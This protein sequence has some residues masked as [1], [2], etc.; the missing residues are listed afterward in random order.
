MRVLKTTCCKM[1][2][3]IVCITMLC[4]VC[5]AADDAASQDGKNVR[6]VS[7]APSLTE[8][9]AD[10][11][12]GDMLVGRSSACDYPP[13][14]VDLPVAGDFGRPFLEA[15]RRLNPDLVVATDVERPQVMAYL[16]QAG[17]R[18][19][20]R[21]CESWDEMMEAALVISETLGDIERGE[22]WVEQM[23][24]RRRLLEE[25]VA[26]YWKERQR[27]RVFV[28]VWGTP[29]T[30]AGRGSFLN[31]LVTMAGGTPL[32][33]KLPGSYVRIN[34]EWVLRENPDIILLMNP[35]FLQ[36]IERLPG[37]RDMKALRKDQVISSIDPDLIN[38]PGPRMIEGAEQLAARLVEMATA[39]EQT[40]PAGAPRE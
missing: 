1:A 10:L 31:D 35:S 30:T 14:V 26:E 27:P 36:Q 33:V 40:K 6:V 4:I 12:F 7:L 3:M 15:L 28:Y 21:P 32:G 5:V 25:Q 17:I 24:E 13:E 29:L 20:Q 34:T 39:A 23:R 11:G 18:T 16:Q 19:L 38:R 2:G 22:Q 37:W 9:I 8:L